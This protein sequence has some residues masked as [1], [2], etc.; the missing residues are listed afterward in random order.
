MFVAMVIGLGAMIW[1]LLVDWQ[2]AVAV[3]LAMSANN[4]GQ[5]EVMRD[6]VEDMYG[7]RP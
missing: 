4:F 1:M 6:R 7:R 5:R 2:I 3:Y